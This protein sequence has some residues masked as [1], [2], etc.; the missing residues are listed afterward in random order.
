MTDFTSSDATEVALVIPFTLDAMGNI[1]TTTQQELIWSNR[2]RSA[3][4]TRL[5]ERVMRPSYGT[6]IGKS[7]FNTGSFM[8]AAIG[9]EVSRVFH[10]YLPL[11]TLSSV[12]NT[13]D[14]VS[15][16]LTSEISYQ[17]PNKKEVT[18]EIGTV[19]VSTT[20]PPYEEYK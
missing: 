20:N 11:L 6:T 3:I 17:L 18:T 14:E 1:V 4:G 5:T 2:V 8:E 9:T 15:G 19:V 10:E 12:S 13:Y 16:I 7:L